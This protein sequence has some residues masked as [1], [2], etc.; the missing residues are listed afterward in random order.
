MSLQQYNFYPILTPV[1]AV[2]ASNVAGS[3]SNGPT[4]NGVKATLTIAASSLTVDGVA[5]AVGD[6]LLLAAQTAANQNGIYD[7]FSIDSSVVLQRS[8]DLNDAE[9]LKGGLQVGVAAGSSNAGSVWTLVEPLPATF[10]VSDMLFES[11]ATPG[12]GSQTF[13]NLTVTGALT[14]PSAY[15]TAFNATT[16]AV[17]G[18]SAIG[19]KRG[20]TAAYAG[21]GTS[22]AFVATGLVATDIVV[23]TI[24]ASTNAVGLAKAVP[25]ANTLTVTFTA[26]PGAATT[27]NWI[28]IP[29]V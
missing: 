9:N 2:S 7:V 29:T 17:A 6:R 28:A 24:L 18:I 13:N 27:V 3:Y 12:G 25:T 20:T 26:D 22:N 8:D 4:N 5:M 23:A 1:R 21:G 11:S 10:G 14:L 15:A 16:G 19:I